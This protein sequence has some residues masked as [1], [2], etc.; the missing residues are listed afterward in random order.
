MVKP[1]PSR[2]AGLLF[3]AVTALFVE[4]TALAADP[5]PAPTDAK[6]WENMKPTRRGGFTLGLLAG[7]GVAS[8]VGFPND[9]KKINR[10]RYYTETG[11]RPASTGALWLGGALTDW[12][13]FGIGFGSGGMFATGD[14]SVTTGGLI[15]HL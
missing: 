5:P 10:A 11:T 12:F 15:F 4:N 7:F 8:V 2:T 6:A 3:A 14:Y 1:F 13:T 9:A